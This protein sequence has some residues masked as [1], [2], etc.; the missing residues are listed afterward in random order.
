MQQ[1]MRFKMIDLSDESGYAVCIA[2][3]LVGCRGWLIIIVTRLDVYYNIK[4]IQCDYFT[5]ALG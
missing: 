3:D 1:H 2:E 5:M 4:L